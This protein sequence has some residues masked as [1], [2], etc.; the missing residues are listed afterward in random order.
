MTA[1]A[2]PI[3]PRPAPPADAER[4]VGR[5][6]LDGVDW[7]FYQR[8]LDATRD[9]A[10]RITYD[11]G[12]LE[13]EMPSKLH[14]RLKTLAHDCLTAYCAHRRIVVE[15]AGSTTWK[16]QD[17]DGGLE[18][19][20]SYYFVH[21]CD[22]AAADEVDLEAGDPPP[23]LAVE[24]DLSPPRVSKQ[25]VY[26]RLGVPEIWRWRDERLTV[27]LRD[28]SGTYSPADRSRCLP[29]FPLDRLAAA[30]SDPGRPPVSVLVEAFRQSLSYDA[31]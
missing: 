10:L 27:L 7:D 1:I 25:S 4:V 29:D 8:L 16:R 30:L 14:E 19:D 15:P 2:A 11:R 22:M 9:G 31:T 18:A 23:E 20:E 21:A 12:R 6:E 17:R 28:A 13:I 24:I 5:V 26:A 3:L